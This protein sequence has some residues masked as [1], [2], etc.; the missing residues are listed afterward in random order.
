M[1]MLKLLSPTTHLVDKVE[2]DNEFRNLLVNKLLDSC[3]FCF[4]LHDSLQDYF[5]KI[6]YVI[7]N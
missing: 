2:V 3:T 5:C 4:F 7:L 1:E 6:Y